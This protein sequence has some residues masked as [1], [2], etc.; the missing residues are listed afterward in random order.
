VSAQEKHFFL[1]SPQPITLI[2]F[3]ACRNLISIRSSISRRRNFIS[4]GLD[5]RGHDISREQ[6]GHDISSGL[7]PFI[8]GLVAHHVLAS[9]SAEIRVHPLHVEDGLVPFVDER[10]DLLATR[11]VLRLVPTKNHL[12]YHTLV[13]FTQEFKLLHDIT[14]QLIFRRP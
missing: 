4:C 5:L 12:I 8:V 6:L 9:I 7:R 10:A 2:I 14:I 3:A 13:F 11:P 1:R